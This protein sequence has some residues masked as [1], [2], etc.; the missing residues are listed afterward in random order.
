[1]NKKKFDPKKLQKLNHPGR[2]LDIPPD[3]VWD[4]LN[5]K[6]PGVFVDI[7]AG[8]ERPACFRAAPGG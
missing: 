8:A 7:G 4:K 2:L 1:M 5:L 6:H 3:K